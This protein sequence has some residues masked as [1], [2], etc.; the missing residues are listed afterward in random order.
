MEVIQ[1]RQDE[2]VAAILAERKYRISVAE[3]DAMIKAGIFDED[4]PIELIEGELVTMPPIGDDHVNITVHLGFILYRLQTQEKA[5]VIQQNPIR[6]ARSEPQPDFV[7][8]GY[9]ANYQSGVPNAADVLLAI[10]VSDSTLRIDK[11]VKTKLYAAAAIPE[12]WIV[13]VNHLTVRQYWQP[14]DGTYL[15]IKQYTLADAITSISF[16]DFT[17]R[18]SDIFGRTLSETTPK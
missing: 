3:Y 6:L 1:E 2:D 7:L 5:V 8:V 18:V 17:L 16:P 12:Y 14:K 15:Q 11:N 13:D 9:V 4:A 10:E